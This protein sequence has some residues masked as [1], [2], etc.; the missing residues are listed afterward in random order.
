MLLELLLSGI[1]YDAAT[2]LVSLAHMQGVT[3]AAKCKVQIP[4]MPPA[5]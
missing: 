4:H 5:F 1:Q 2:T 3:I